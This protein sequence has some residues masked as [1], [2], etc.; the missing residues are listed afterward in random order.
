[1]SQAAL[2]LADSNG[3]TFLAALNAALLRL[4]TQG[5]GTGRPSDIQAYET[6]VDTDTPGAGVATWYLWD[7][8]SDIALGTVN[9]STHKFALASAVLDAL[10]GSTQGLLP[11][12]DAAAWTGLAVGSDAYQALFSGGAGAN[13]AWGGTWK[14]LSTA[15]P[16]GASSLDFI[17]IPAGIN[18]LKVLFDLLPATTGVSLKLRT[19]GAD[20]VIDAGATD[21]QCEQYGWNSGATAA[22]QAGGSGLDYIPLSFVANPVSNDAAAGGIS[23]FVL[24]ENIQAA[25][26]TRCQMVANYGPDTAA[27]VYIALQGAGQRLEADRITGLRFLFSAGNLSGRAH[28]FGCS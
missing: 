6:W 3:A 20:G 24:F 23:G 14:L 11:Y 8:A 26:H 7:G 10:L 13:P 17:S 15:T 19:F 28:L 18:H 4:A 1:M 12:R 25:R 9:T 16:S 22:A 27:S 2:T 21:Y 5:S